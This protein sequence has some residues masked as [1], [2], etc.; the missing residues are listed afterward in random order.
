V[1]DNRLIGLILIFAP[2]SLISF[3][4]GQAVIADVQR[5][6][7]GHG[8]LTDQQFTDLFAVSRA[9]PGPSSLITAL[10]GYQIY[11]L[12]GAVVALFATFV[13]SSIVVYAASAWWQRHP[14]S[15]IKRAIERGLAPVAIGLIFAGAL[16]V[17]QAAH[18][19][20]LAIATTIVCT[21]VL[22][23]ANVTPYLVVAVVALV[24]LAIHFLA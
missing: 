8:W 14:I 16:A 21:A 22:Y 19:G 10:I 7:V 3:G 18:V 2:L 5:Q 13:P 9:A 24:Y 23:F 15:P 17:M 20:L 6:T 11:G 4:G 12:L 1:A